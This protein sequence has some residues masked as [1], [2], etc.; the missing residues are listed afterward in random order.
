MLGRRRVSVTTYEHDDQGRLVRAITVHDPEWLD[1][2]RDWAAADLQE[3]ANACEGCG[4]PRDETTDPANEGAYV[5]LE[6]VKCHGCAPMTRKKEKL[7]D[8]RDHIF[9]VRKVR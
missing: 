7:E 9:Q 4:F 5:A 2:D 3:Q 1:D 6:P 8:P